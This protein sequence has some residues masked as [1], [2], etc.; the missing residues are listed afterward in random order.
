MPTGRPTE[1]KPQYIEQ[2]TEFAAA[3]LTDA[4][5]AEE[6]GVNASTIWR[7]KGRFPEFCNALK[8]A[9]DVADERVIR[10]LY[11]KALAGDVTACIF[12]LKNRRKEE[13]RDRH[14]HEH[15][16][17]LGIKVIALHAAVEAAKERP[18]LKP[19]FDDKLIEGE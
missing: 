11:Q 9:K 18:A 15:S 13:W 12:W 10:S 3:G 1:F 6:L 14:E 7:W 17:E 5:I 19:A 2:V 4:E 16:G 8:C